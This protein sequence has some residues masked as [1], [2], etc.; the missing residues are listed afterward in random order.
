LFYSPFTEVRSCR[1]SSNRW[2]RWW[3]LKWC[4]SSIY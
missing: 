1:W 2:N 3:K 4:C